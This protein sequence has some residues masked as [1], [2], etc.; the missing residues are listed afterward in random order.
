VST[1]LERRIGK[2]RVEAE[3]DAPEASQPVREQVDPVDAAIRVAAAVAN[4]PPAERHAVLRSVVPGET[5]RLGKDGVSVGA[6]QSRARRVAFSE[7]NIDKAETF[8]LNLSEDQRTAMATGDWLEQQPEDRKALY[9]E[10]LQRIAI[11]KNNSVEVN[12]Q[13]PAL[14]ESD[15][16]QAELDWDDDDYEETA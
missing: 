8:L 13:M 16:A 2:L 10:A 9:E 14:D 4:K 6:T 12:W 1:E 11:R 15:D 3:L 5:V 7:A